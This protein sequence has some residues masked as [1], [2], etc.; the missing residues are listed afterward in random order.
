M[1]QIGLDDRDLPAG[2][3]AATP[4]WSGVSADHSRALTAR[5]P[6]ASQG[7]LC[8]PLMILGSRESDR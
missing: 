7:A 6:S 1:G 5:R 2:G 8:P 3:T 4:C